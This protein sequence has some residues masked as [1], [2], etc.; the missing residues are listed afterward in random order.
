MTIKLNS[1]YNSTSVK[2]IKTAVRA[3][4]RFLTIPDE[5]YDKNHILNNVD[6]VIIFIKSL[7]TNTAKLY[8]NYYVKL[9]SFEDIVIEKLQEA[10]KET[11]SKADNTRLENNKQKL[12]TLDPEAFYQYYYNQLHGK[13]KYLDKRNPDKVIERERD[14][15][16]SITRCYRV[17]LFSILSNMPLRLTEL[18]NMKFVDD[19]INNFVDFNNNQLVIRKHKNGGIYAL[20]KHKKGST[21]FIILKER[22]M[23][24]IKYLKDKMNTTFLFSKY[25]NGIEMSMNGQDIEQLSRTAINTYNKAHGVKH[26]KGHMGIHGLRQNKVSTLYT[27]LQIKADEIKKIIDLSRSLGHGLTT[28]SRDYLKKIET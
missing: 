4:Y 25:I 10:L 3:L 5:S 15:K 7:N 13:V 20:K 26:I 28:A 24:D 14:A 2:N 1:K 11:I 16:F 23:N 8:L 27:E 12:I 21:R 19:K 6:N 18:S 9:L 22:T 17:C